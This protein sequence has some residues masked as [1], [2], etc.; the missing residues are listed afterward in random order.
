MEIDHDCLHSPVV[1]DEHWQ[2]EENAQRAYA[3]QEGPDIKCQPQDKEARRGEESPA[4]H[5][6]NLMLHTF[7]S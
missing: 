5:L 7:Y 6:S 4:S 3:A 1:T 2:Q